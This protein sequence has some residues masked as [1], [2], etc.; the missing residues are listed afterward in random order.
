MANPTN[1]A[2]AAEVQT[3]F[4]GTTLRSMLLQAYAFGTVG[5]LA[6]IASIVSFV[7]AGLM[8]V[9]SIAGFAHMRQVPV[10]KEVFAPAPKKSEWIPA[11]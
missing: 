7:L 6:F 10:D 9:L 5:T 11:S 2:L 1:A 3:V 8:L 4:R